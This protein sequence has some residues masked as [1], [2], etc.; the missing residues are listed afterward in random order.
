[1]T[2]IM[3]NP[4]TSQRHSASRVS[5][6]PWSDA[7]ASAAGSMRKP[8]GSGAAIQIEGWVAAE[9]QTTRARPL[10]ALTWASLT[11]FT[12]SR[13]RSSASEHEA[14]CMPSTTSCDSHTCAGLPDTSG[15]GWLNS[16]HSAGSSKTVRCATG[17]R[18]EVG[19]LAKATGSGVRAAA[20]M[21]RG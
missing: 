3:Q 6:R 14:Q 16:A 12:R 17:G 5:L 21:L 10:D 13:A 1:M 7:K 2:C 19:S 20:C 18:F 4:A 11:P 15:R 8:S 9:D